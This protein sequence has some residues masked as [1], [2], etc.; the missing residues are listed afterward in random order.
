MAARKKVTIVGAGNV[1]GTTAMRLAERGYADVVLYDIVEGLPQ[2]KALDLQ[3]AAPVEG[4]DCRVVGTND[5][6]ETA[7]SDVVVFTSGAPRKPGM[8][9]D[10]LLF[11]NQKIVE[12]NTAKIVTQSPNT[13]M[14]MVNNPLDAMAQL[15]Y[16]RSGFPKSRVVGQAGILDTARFRTFLAMELGVSFRDVQAYVLG[17]HGDDMVPILSYTTVGGVPVGKLLPPA[18]L[19]ALV[20]RTRKGGAEIVELLKTG[21]AFYAPSA[22][23][24][25]M[26]DA[27]LLDRKRILPC[28]AYLEGEYGISDLFVGVPVVL[29][30]GGVE[31]VIEIELTDD[32]RTALNRTA[33]SVR[34][35]VRTMGL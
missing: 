25:E 10:D 9:R 19:E 28:S 6:A 23:V 13:I 34:E 31:R 8:S 2:G 15:A 1:G 33:S 24:M 22:G 35:L 18:R 17:G 14:L 4:Y 27:I 3:E 7:G 20:D 5:Y 30:A 12:E 21:S 26:L 29:G 16:K 11:T 32:E